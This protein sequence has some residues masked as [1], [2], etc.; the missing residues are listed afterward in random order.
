M[1]TPYNKTSTAYD[2]S[3]FD[4]AQRKERKPEPK[5]EEYKPELKMVQ[6][7]AAK[8]GRPIAV[9]L[10]A[11]LFLAVFI[12]FLYSKAQLSEVNLKVSEETAAYESAQMLNGQLKSELNGS[13]S[14]D[15]VEEYAL[16]ELGM[17]KVNASQ[18]RY[19]EMNI[20]VMTET[21]ESEDENIFVSIF[22]WFG[23]VLEYLG[24]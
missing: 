21:A 16:K 9:I 24:F 1:P 17:Q 12:M 6:T 22:N 4:T 18:E 23:G 10:T 15:N 2:L 3:L 14:I 13:V 8:V 5:P 19:A 20:G 7:S 11:G